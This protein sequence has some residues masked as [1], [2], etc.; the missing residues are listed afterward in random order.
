MPSLHRHLQ[1]HGPEHDRLAF[2][3]DCPICIPRLSG[4][5]PDP[6]LLSHS[7]E[8]T[9]ATGL[10]LAGSLLPVAHASA[11][12]DA[13]PSFS[14]PPAVLADSGDQGEGNADAGGGGGDQ[15]PSIAD[16][17]EDSVPP[18][19]Q[20]PAKSP[21]VELEPPQSPESGPDSSPSA[22]S[23]S[24]AGSGGSGEPSSRPPGAGSGASRP[25]SPAAD[26]GLSPRNPAE[27]AGSDS[28]SPSGS[29]DPS[30][31]ASDRDR[32]DE[33]SGGARRD[34]ASDSPPGSG[35]RVVVQS[36]DCLWLIAER[37]LGPDADDEQV[38]AAVERIWQRNAQRIGTG[39]PDLIYPGQTLDLP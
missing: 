19:A 25:R 23:S 9:L 8:A 22:P 6:R 32:P 4:R 21:E 30:R 26:P 38:A 36:G 39:N 16:G 10:V 2:R 24:E 35:S 31:D 5:Y 11:G 12:T 17:N 15:A 33:Q 28:S 7:G 3:P 37:A 18:A 34:P 27:G 14:T 20:S 29:P 1:L 13:P